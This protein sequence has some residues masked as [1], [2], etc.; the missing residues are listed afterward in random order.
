MRVLY[1][2]NKLDVVKGKEYYVNFFFLCLVIHPYFDLT[3]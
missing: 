3:N 1:L 2:L